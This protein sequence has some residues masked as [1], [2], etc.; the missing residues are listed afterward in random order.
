MAG[1]PPPSGP[2][3]AASSSTSSSSASA[4][5]YSQLQQQQ[6][7]L[8]Q[9]HFAPAN[10]VG[11]YPYQAP[12]LHV[13]GVPGAHL[14]LGGPPSAGASNMQHPFDYAQQPLLP[15]Q[16]QHPAAPHPQPQQ[17]H[18]AYPTAAQLPPHL[19]PHSQSHP[20][21][22]LQGGQ[23][24]LGSGPAPPLIHP[25][26]SI[27]HPSAWP[28]AP[29]SQPHSHP[30]PP[31]HLLD[32]HHQHPHHPV[33]LPPTASHAA[34]QAHAVHPHAHAPYDFSIPPSAPS[35]QVS[36]PL[37]FPLGD[38]SQP[39][40][41][42]QQYHGG[43]PHAH[44]P[45]GSLGQP[46]PTA[47]FRAAKRESVSQDAP[48]AQSYSGEPQPGPAALQQQ[49]A[50]AQAQA[51]RSAAE[52]VAQLHIS[53]RSVQPQPANGGDANVQPGATGGSARS[54]GSAQSKASGLVAARDMQA[55]AKGG[56]YGSAVK[57]EPG[58]YEDALFPP[59]A[60]PSTLTATCP[61]SPRPPQPPPRPLDR[62]PRRTSRPRATGAGG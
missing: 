49:Q 38:A 52:I 7:Q 24:G 13:Q 4:A 40:Q 54:P 30:H 21:L 41:H 60:D 20:S 11:P 62:A 57:S 15:P 31:S 3:A 12:P 23:P 27:I 6:Q 56:S 19:L 46:Q 61:R 44:V 10:G 42:L 34:G 26:A 53:L 43:A 55:D 36:P 25:G 48:S 59:S 33:H 35:S 8:Q 17:H 51:Q 32:Q 18:Y 39:P 28:A 1:W 5:P 37:S 9:Q 22:H 2:S 47:I 16:L 50:Q 14:S 45:S 29:P 58:S